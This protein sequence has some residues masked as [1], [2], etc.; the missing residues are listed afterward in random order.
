M[1]EYKEQN[2]LDEAASGLLAEGD[3]L[4][5]EVDSGL[6][7]PT[8]LFSQTAMNAL[9]EAANTAL[10]AGGMEGDYPPFDSDITEFPMEFVRL[11]SMLVDASVETGAAVDLDLAGIEDD[12]D[13]AMLAANLEALAA[14]QA[15]VSGMTEEAS[16]EPSAGDD[17]EA[18]MM[19]RV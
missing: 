6:E 9:V 14:D 7:V 2:A 10:A 13:V 8:G 3:S 15:Y 17:D 1:A 16:V 19:G 4:Q 18:F 12:T 5:G 11:L